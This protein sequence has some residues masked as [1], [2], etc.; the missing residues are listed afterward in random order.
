MKPSS[1]T[2][3]DVKSLNEN[4]NQNISSK[5]LLKQIKE[6]QILKHQKTAQK[7]QGVIH[8][9]KNKGLLK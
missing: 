9:M 3:Q 8:Q 5:I 4:N 7:K 2:P 6:I 1:K